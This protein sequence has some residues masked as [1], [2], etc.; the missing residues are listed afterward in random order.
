MI[1]NFGADVNMKGRLDGWTPLHAACAHDHHNLALKLVSDF[2]A[3]LSAADNEGNTPLELS[4][5]ADKDDLWVRKF[6]LTPSQI[7]ALMNIHVMFH[8]TLT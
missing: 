5:E 1:E 8:P 3:D 6:H 2:G 7:P 4:K